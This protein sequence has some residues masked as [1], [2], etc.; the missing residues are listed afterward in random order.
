MP[1]RTAA[2][3]IVVGAGPAGACAAF[4]LAQAGVDVVLVD[5]AAFPRDKPCGDGVASSAMTVLAHMGLLDWVTGSGFAEPQEL[6]LI[7]PGGTTARDRLDPGDGLSFG[8][9]IP[10]LALDAALVERAVAAG[11]RLQDRMRIVGLE[12]LNAHRVR[13]IGRAAG[14]VRLDAPLVIA[15][16]GGTSSFTR[17]LGLVPGPPEL[18][19]V[20][21]YVAGDVGD[22]GVAEI[23]WQRSIAPGY[24][25][26][27][28]V[29][30]G[31]ANV[32]IGAYSTVVRRRGL[33]LHDRWRAF[34][35]SPQ[36]RARL[37]D[38][39]PI[40]PV[41]GHPL[42]TDADRVTPLADNVLL[43]GEAAG[44]VS[45]LTGEGIGPSLEC[46]HLAAIHACRALERGDLTATSL[47][48]YGRAFHRRFD[49]YHRSARM[50]RRLLSLPWLVNRIVRL[51]RRDPDFARLLSMI[52]I[53]VT[54]PATALTPLT[55]A[56]ILMG[57]SSS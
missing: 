49:A 35:T 56:R 52:I 50:L 45:P 14:S 29:G 46:G 44:V 16:D 4:F 27:F 12:R 9:V 37:A 34:L 31:Q 43:A 21:G 19:A 33:N 54:F 8:Y 2:Q 36:A 5:Q 10:R 6:L 24:G 13:L 28:P 39:R 26:I 23:H 57:R 38:A 22:A 47:A 32:G 40:G 7:S 41:K 20:R 48:H 1:A 51:A 11:A 25:W 53:G 3:V 18:V 55:I 17:R 30:N 15:A 42:R